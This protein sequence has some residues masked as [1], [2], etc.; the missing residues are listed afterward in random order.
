MPCAMAAGA[1]PAR[2][3]LAPDSGYVFAHPN[4]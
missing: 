3:E 1:I 4:G 2:E